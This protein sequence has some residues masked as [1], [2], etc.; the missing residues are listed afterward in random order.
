MSTLN[1]DF[2]ALERLA[3][4]P[5]GK[6]ADPTSNMSP[7]DAAKWKT[8]NEEHKDKFKKTAYFTIYLPP[9]DTKWHDPRKTLSRGAF[10]S[11]QEADQWVAKN[12]P[13]YKYTVQE[14]DDPEV[15]EKAI[16]EVAR[17]V[18]KAGDQ[19][20][21]V[22]RLP[23]VGVREMLSKKVVEA[24]RGILYRK[25]PAFSRFVKS[26]RGVH[27]ANGD[28]IQSF[29]DNPDKL[30]EKQKR[31]KK[32]KVAT[33]DELAVL[34]MEL[35][36]GGIP[37]VALDRDM[38][39][40][41]LHARLAA[42]DVS[43]NSQI[44]KTI[45]EQMGGAR[46]MRMIGAT[47]I[48]W[49]KDGVGV[50]WPNKSPAKGNYFEVHL[51]PM[52]E[53][54]L[55]F[56][57]VS[58]RGKKLV[59]KFNGVQW[60]QLSKLFEQQT[61]WYLRMASDQLGLVAGGDE[62]LAKFEEGESAD[63]TENMSEE[64]AKKWRLEN[65]KNKDKFKAAF[66]DGL[67][68]EG[69]PDNLDEAKCK[70]WEANTEKYKDVVKD[71]AK[72][73]YD[74]G[75][76][77]PDGWDS[78]H[79]E[80]DPSST[81]SNEGSDTPDG[82]GNLGKRAA[83]P[84]TVNLYGLMLNGG[85]YGTTE[86]KR[87]AYTWSY[88]SYGDRKLVK[89]EQRDTARVIDL[90][91]V[92]L[93]VIAEQLVDVGTYA[94]KL[95]PQAAFRLARPY[96]KDKGFKLASQDKEAG[97]Y[98]FT[99][100]VQADCESGIRKVQ[101]VAARIAKAAYSKNEKAAEFLTAH[102]RRADSLPAQILVAAL[103][104]IGPKVAAEMKR[105]ARLEELRAQ[106]LAQFEE[107][108]PAD[109]TKD[110]SP[111]DAKRW[112]EENAKHKDQFKEAAGPQGQSQTALLAA[113]EKWPKGHSDALSDIARGAAFRGVHFAKIMSAAEA[114]DKKGLLSFD[115]VKVTKKAAESTFRPGDSATWN[116]KK[117]MIVDTHGYPVKTVDLR[118]TESGTGG[119][120]D[121]VSGHKR[122][123]PVGQLKKASGSMRLASDKEARRHG[124]YGFHDKVATL[125][126]TA[127][128]EV[129]AEAGRIAADLHGRRTA[130][131]KSITAFLDTH[132]KTANCKYSRLL[133]ASYPEENARVASNTTPR[134]VQAWLEW[135]E[136]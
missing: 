108:K 59:K 6:P 9:G 61:G 126:L 38:A 123:V 41:E 58:V 68:A 99:K 122:G 118:W 34:N 23:A 37:E 120:K 50:K 114:L 55:E 30:K 107:G 57:N 112:Q 95:S 51:T 74:E 66:D 16:L 45:I 136:A 97:L 93:G 130:Q 43:A 91:H 53:Y 119:A 8:M 117:V 104:E 75:S 105:T 85:L 78:G 132:C 72:T 90:Y 52:D 102:A 84:G 28:M 5:E 14:I 19:G 40:L 113:I 83:N 18:A 106:R 27:L 86:N 69:C 89:D 44:G 129:R 134:T 7:E 2:D 76:R 87:D 110:M 39:A 100:K 67:L 98:G 65:L 94:G 70:E 24:E 62:Q 25:E 12:V 133:H 125:G 3:R 64:D 36:A 15:I 35:T 103:G 73:A 29:A 1:N 109:P 127:C 47:Q 116:G 42:I 10:K 82:E 46:A 63:P 71:Q 80:G 33:L 56:Y 79:I 96:M 54:N 81:E 11:R 17:A 128:S 111:E 31:D 121:E 77:I 32:N 26:L 13:G 131:H 48:T 22:D 20:V 4:F 101:K 21:R 49:L 92:P 135:D 115:G 124:L 60:D 88:W